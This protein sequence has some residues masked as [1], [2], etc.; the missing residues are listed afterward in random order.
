MRQRFAR[1]VDLDGVDGAVANAQAAR[2]GGLRFRSTGAVDEDHQ[3]GF[4]R[5]VLALGD[6]FSRLWL[7]LDRT[8]LL[9]KKPPRHLQVPSLE[10]DRRF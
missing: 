10:F 3:G 1:V 4:R 5:V 9:R 7:R 6:A 2:G 8:F